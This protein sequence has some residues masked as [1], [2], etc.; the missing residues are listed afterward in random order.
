MLNRAALILRYKQPFV[1]RIS[2]ADPSSHTPTYRR[3]IIRD[4]AAF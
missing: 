1:D 4:R 3:P 2:A